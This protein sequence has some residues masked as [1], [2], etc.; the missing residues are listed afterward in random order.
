MK[1]IFEEVLPSKDVSRAEWYKKA[2][3]IKQKSS[4][5]KKSI[6]TVIEDLALLA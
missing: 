3:E 5:V 6:E 1:D 4:Q 2:V